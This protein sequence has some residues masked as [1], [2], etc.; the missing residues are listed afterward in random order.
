MPSRLVAPRA[1]RSALPLALAAAAAALSPARL[2]AQAPTP[3]A[4]NVGRTAFAARRQGAITIDGRLDEPAWSRAKPITGFYQTQPTQGAAAT[5]RAELRILYGDR[6][7][8]IG[9]RMYDSL[10]ARGVHERL[11]RRDQLLTLQGDNGTGAPSVT[12]DVLVIHLDTYHDRLGESVFLINPEGVKGDALSIGGSNLDPAWDPVWE[13]AARVDSLGWTAELRIPYSQLRF[14]RDS[15]QTWGLQI[16]RFVDRLNEW[17]AWAFVRANETGGPAKY[18]TLTGIHVDHQPRTAELLPYVLTGDRFAAATAG[19]PFHGNAAA[20]ERVGADLR[21][22][23][24]SNLT[25]DAT[26]NPDFGQVEADPAVVNLSAFETFFPE[27]RPFF[28]A[29]AGAFS[30]GGTSC[31][32]CS[33]TSSLD[34][35][36]SRRIGRAPQ[37]GDSVANTS[38]FSDVPDATRILGAAKIT[39]RTANG[40]TVGVLDAVTGSETARYRTALNGPTLLQPVEPLTNY[41]VGRVKRDYNGGNTIVGGIVTSTERSLGDPMLRG[42]LR[43]RA[44]SG[45]LDMHHYWADQTYDV[46]GQIA[47]SDVG[48]SASAIARTMESSAHYFQRPDRGAVRDGLFTTRFDSTATELRGYGAYA[49]VAKDAGNWLWEFSQAAR[50]PGFEVNDISYLS[51]ADYYWVS[52]NLARQWT[53]PGSWYRN[54]VSIVG[55]QEQFDY[56]DDRT[57]LQ[58]QAFIGVEFPNYWN[59]RSYGI[60]HP[61]VYDP[62]MLRGGPVVKRP[63]Y[64]DIGFGLTSDNRQEVVWGV[65]GD[66]ATG[67][68][69]LNSNFDV[70]PS[71]TFKLG[72]NANV[73]FT[74]TYQDGKGLQYVTRTIDPTDSAFA[75]ARYVLSTIHPTSLSLDTR[76]NMTFTPDVTLELYLQ[77]YFASGHYYSFSEYG[78]PRTLAQRVFGRDVGTISAQRDATGA[79]TTYVVDPDGAGPAPSF[80]FAN[81]DFSY[82]SLRGN[83]VLRWEYRPGSTIY[84]VWQQQR[85]GSSVDG[86]F[87][88]GRDR[89]A[90]FQD[91][92]INVFQLKI[93]YWIGR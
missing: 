80:S 89:A 93:N 92:P 57:D 75:G 72:P 43:D 40:F 63:G 84:L 5:Q 33:N 17:D 15:L 61:A 19:D 79:V 16:Q 2:A 54:I 3:A 11:A 69:A 58:Q 28:V 12:S 81:P 21:Y 74:P 32:F 88:L 42:Y 1:L 64:N 36:Y 9:A 51:R 10:G 35:F 26:V 71:V 76:L 77:P 8:Y 22:L 47:F 25:L 85:S 68:G 78:A 59:L 18:G 56:E 70:T 91:R 49:R 39:G 48:G 45:G 13:G 44:Q 50:S 83:A 73:D 29:G 37:L 30:F 34:L 86:S 66:W 53:V 90:L 24:T 60:H 41:F 23:L 67:V 27:K 46:R 38:L 65:N 31:M 20:T 14:S 4:M 87:D 6:A 62:T 52:A 82:T 55:G 7:I